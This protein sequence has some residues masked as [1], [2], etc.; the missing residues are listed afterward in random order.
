M[1]AWRSPRHRRSAPA[2]RGGRSTLWLRRKGWRCG[3]DRKNG[4]RTA[5]QLQGYRTRRIQCQDK[6]SRERKRGEF[7]KDFE[8]E[9]GPR[10]GSGGLGGQAFQLVGL[11]YGQA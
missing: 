4:E 7:I 1:G 10:K 8:S 2:R 6:G 11:D 9:L 3:A 5:L